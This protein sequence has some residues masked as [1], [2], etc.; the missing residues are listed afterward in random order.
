MGQGR[1]DVSGMALLETRVLTVELPAPG[2]W[3][4]PVNE[5]SV[6]INAGESV[7]LVAESDSGK[8]MLSLAL[9]GLL[10]LGARENGPEIFSQPG[11][12]SQSE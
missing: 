8:T 6:R 7:G 12:Y 10:P 1:Y 9:M 5:V 2:G 3:I 4:R 11:T